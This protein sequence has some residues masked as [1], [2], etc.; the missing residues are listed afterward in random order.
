LT[1][2]PATNKSGTAHRVASLDGATRTA[3]QRKE[4]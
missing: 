1:H 3:D 4:Y 2:T